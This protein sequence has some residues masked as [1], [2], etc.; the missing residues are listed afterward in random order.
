MSQGIA[1]GNT[2]QIFAG[3]SHAQVASRESWVSRAWSFV[4]VAFP[5][6][7]IFL[8]RYSFILF[9][10]PLGYGPFLCMYLLLPVFVMR[11]RFPVRVSQKVCRIAITCQTEVVQR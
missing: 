1:K 4:L 5:F 8:F 10:G 3:Y 9:P 6:I 2:K 11:Y 7:D